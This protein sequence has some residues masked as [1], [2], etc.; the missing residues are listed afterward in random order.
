V[1]QGTEILM[2]SIATLTIIFSVFLFR[3]LPVIQNSAFRY[4]LR[5]DFGR[6][7][8]EIFR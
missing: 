6:Y 3:W 7:S 5:R 8:E 4:S 1:K 2:R